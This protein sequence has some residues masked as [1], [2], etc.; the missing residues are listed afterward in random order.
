MLAKNESV[1]IKSWVW[2]SDH[3]HRIFNGLGTFG[4]AA[5]GLFADTTKG[6]WCM[7]Q[8]TTPGKYFV[9]FGVVYLIGCITGWCRAD[10]ISELYN[11]LQVVEKD[12]NT[13]LK[14]KESYKIRLQSTLIQAN[15]DYFDLF[16]EQLSILSNDVLNLT[17]KERV[18]IYKHTGSYFIMLG[19]YSLNSIY[20]ARGRSVYPDTQG[21]IGEAWVSGESFIDNLPCPIASIAKYQKELVKHGIGKSVIS[22]FKMKSRNLWACR[23]NQEIPNKSIAVI[24]IESIDTNRLKKEELNNVMS[25]ERRRILAFLF[26][27]R[28]MEPS[29]YIAVSEGL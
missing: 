12:K 21:C 11:K 20:D 25:I 24:V 10:R 9:L 22:S 8:M 4:I 29:P 7:V 5:S 13:A 14:E 26:A 28:E 23:I 15:K 17:D 16:R 3:Y 19:R 18:S 2:L 6:F 1:F 27:H